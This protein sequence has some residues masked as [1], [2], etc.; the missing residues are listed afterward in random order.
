MRISITDRCNL[1][2]RYCMPAEGIEK[3]SMSQILTYEEILR[4]CRAAAGLG[5][6]KFKVTGGEPLVRKGCA[7]FCG[8]L[9]G[10]PG[11]QQVTLTTNG[12]LLAGEIG[13]L[14]EAGID[15]I[16]ISLD[17]LRE[18]RYR[19][20]TCGGRLEDTLKGLDAAIASGIPT[21]V[22]CLLQRG[23]N[24]DEL[25]R[26]AELAFRRGIDV[27][28]IEIM[29]IGF[30]RPETGLSNEAVLQRLER[31]YPDLVRDERIHGNGPAVYYRL[32]GNDSP[33]GSIGLI[34][35]MHSSFC[36]SCNRIRLTSQG[37]VKPCLCYED[38]ISL[39]PAL[40]KG[41]QEAL[42][43]ALRDAIDE[44]PAGHTFED[45]GSVDRRAMMQIGG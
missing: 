22:N 41:S 21:K 2:C 10:I 18:D 28:F 29:P 40:E 33:A 20:I 15:G 45:P 6:R 11:V 9:R 30:G 24:E 3:V 34:S 19:Q 39:K 38:S 13:A 32:G 36:E 4:I 37:E 7:G 27:R 12:Q 1:R 31:L 17:S 5:I 42:Q 35:A 44:K 26:F 14:Q 8:E 23:F 43:H 16:N 25:P